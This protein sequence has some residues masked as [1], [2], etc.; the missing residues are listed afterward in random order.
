[1]RNKNLIKN[2]GHKLKEP[3]EIIKKSLHKY[4]CNLPFKSK[5]FVFINFSEISR[6]KEVC[7]NLPS[8]FEISDISMIVYHLNASIRSTLFNYKQFYLNIHE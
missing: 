5:V 8:S 3:K 6:S 2:S 1:M 7:D 4:R